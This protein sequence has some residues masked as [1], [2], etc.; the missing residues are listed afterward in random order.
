MTKTD[1]NSIAICVQKEI[2]D[3]RNRIMAQQAQANAMQYQANAQAQADH[4]RR[5]NGLRNY[6]NCLQNEGN[7]S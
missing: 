5:M 6:D 4:R 3:E 1:E 2:S 7:F